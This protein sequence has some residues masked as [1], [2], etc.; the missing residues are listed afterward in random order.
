MPKGQRRQSSC[1]GAYGSPLACTHVYARPYTCLHQRIH[2]V[3]AEEESL[4][5]SLPLLSFVCRCISTRLCSLLVFVSV[6]CAGRGSFSLIYDF[7]I[8]RIDRRAFSVHS[9]VAVR[10]V[11]R[12]KESERRTSPL[13]I[14]T[15]AI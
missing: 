3:Y 9:H 15:R 4:F 8:D 13:A 2:K 1:L 11:K 6:D 14:G 5:F 7:L 10:L 12:N